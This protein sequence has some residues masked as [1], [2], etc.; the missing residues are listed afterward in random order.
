VVDGTVGL[1]GHAQALLDAHPRASIVGLDKDDAAL[2]RAT[3]RLRGSG[4]ATLRHASFGS[5]PGVLGELG[6]ERVDGLL[7][8]LGVSS[9]QLDLPARGF[10]FR[11]EGPLDMRM[12]PSMGLSA[13]DYL[14][15]LD[16]P[17]VAKLLR[18]FGE[19]K[20][21]WP[22]AKAIVRQRD[23]GLL[24][25]TSQLAEI[26]RRVYPKGKQRI[27]PATRTFQALRIAVNDELGELTRALDAVPEHF[28]IGGVVC[29]I[30]FHSLEDRIVKQRFALW[31]REGKGRTLKRKP[32]IA[33]ES[34]VALNP[35]ASSAKLR[36]FVW[37][38]VVTKSNER[39]SK[40]HRNPA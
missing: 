1:G 7:L 9:L 40:H 25:T 3:E 5:W 20:L 31:E 26:C 39:R 16:A 13:A 10:S 34:E 18:D 4:R 24:T 6:S 11:A 8:D 22:I 23:A 14:A 27:D 19:E 28:R 2:S 12:D 21:A 17:A 15:G 30:S 35:R 38:E 36:A 32:V 37:G 29:V 33:D